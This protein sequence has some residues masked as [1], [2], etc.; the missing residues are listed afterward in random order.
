MTPSAPSWSLGERDPKAIFLRRFA[1]VRQA[2]GDPPMRTSLSPHRS[3]TPVDAERPDED[4][5]DRR[6]A[7]GATNGYDANGSRDITCAYA[8]RLYLISAT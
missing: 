3:G 7:G 6:Q 5:D 2:V 4:R 1:R 8:H